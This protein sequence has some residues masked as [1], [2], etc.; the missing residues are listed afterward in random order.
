MVTKKSKL[1]ALIE[2]AKNECGI[3]P[4]EGAKAKDVIELIEKHLGR[5]LEGAPEESK[6]KDLNRKA[7][8]DMTIEEKC[9]TKVL[10]TVHEVQG[11]SADIVL[12]GEGPNVQIKR[13]EPVAVRYD[14]Y[15]LL[16]NARPTTYEQ[17][18]K[19]DVVEKSLHAY[20]FTVHEFDYQGEE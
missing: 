11:G 5:E 16:N 8:K 10:L 20:P 13:G 14:I 12:S 15:D 3:N 4:P 7:F 19:D 9:K 2:Y 6:P 17:K 18:G 1:P